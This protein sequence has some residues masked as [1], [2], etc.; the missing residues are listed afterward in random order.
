MANSIYLVGLRRGSPNYGGCSNTVEMPTFCYGS[1]KDAKQ[2]Y[3]VIKGM[4]EH[5]EEGF[6][7]QEPYLLKAIPD[8]EGGEIIAI[9]GSCYPSD[10]QMWNEWSEKG[11][12]SCSSLT[13]SKRQIVWALI[14]ALLGS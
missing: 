14:K 3:L 13:P 1:F 10:C 4:G 9:Y 8:H 12:L 6:E 2:R 5:S 7:Y 11:A